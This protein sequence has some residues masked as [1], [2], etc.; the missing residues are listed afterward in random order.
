[1]NREGY[2]GRTPPNV[3][4]RGPNAMISSFEAIVADLRRWQCSLQMGTITAINGDD[5]VDINIEGSEMTDIVAVGPVSLG[6][7]VPVLIDRKGN[8]VVLGETGTNGDG[9]GPVSLA[10][11]DLTD[12]DSLTATPGQTIVWNGSLWLPGDVAEGG[13]GSGGAMPSLIIASNDAFPMEKDRAD[14]VCDGVSDQVEFNAALAQLTDTDDWYPGATLWLTGGN[15]EMDG[16]VINE[17]GDL[18]TIRGLSAGY[19]GGKA[20]I[21]QD[22]RELGNLAGIGLWEGDTGYEDDENALWGPSLMNLTWTMFKGGRGW[23]IYAANECGMSMYGGPTAAGG[24]DLGWVI[25]QYAR[26][27]NFQTS[28]SGSVGFP[29]AEYAVKMETLG[30]NTNHMT[31]CNVYGYETGLQLETRATMGNAAQHRIYLSNCHFSAQGNDYAVAYEPPDGASA[32][33]SPITMIGC[34][35]GARHTTSGAGYIN[36]GLY[37]PPN[38]TVHRIILQGNYFAANTTGST[39]ILGNGNEQLALINGNIIE[40]NNGNYISGFTNANNMK[41]NNIAT[42]WTVPQS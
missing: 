1:M 15:Y 24:A 5:T 12:V 2:R 29:I 35:V 13:G 10:L 41:T 21:W 26:E 31:N 16:Q 38:V 40:Q 27:S 18:I 7:V 42:P 37:I 25:G 30:D 22:G 11:N 4:N 34:F 17:M 8:V 14:F 19:G 32:V 33:G 36:A 9:G 28:G 3:I 39:A 6:A 20:N 23:W